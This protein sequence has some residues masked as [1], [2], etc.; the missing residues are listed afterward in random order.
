MTTNWRLVLAAL[1]S[2]LGST[3]AILREVTRIVS[4]PAATM[5]AFTTFAPG[6]GRAGSIVRKIARTTLPADMSRTRSLLAIL[7]EVARVSRM[8]T[9][10]HRTCLLSDATTG[11]TRHPCNEEA[12]FGLTSRFWGSVEPAT[13]VANLC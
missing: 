7:R 11:V 5:T 13:F 9:F 4:S 3:L 6:L 2:S 12:P 8:S 1:A 10:R